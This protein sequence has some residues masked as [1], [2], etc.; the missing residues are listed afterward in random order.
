MAEA[1]LSITDD[2][3]E[4]TSHATLRRAYQRLRGA[5]RGHVEAAAPGI[6]DLIA[7][8]R[9]HPDPIGRF[10]RPRTPEGRAREPARRHLPDQRSRLELAR[11]QAF[12]ISRAVGAC[13]T[14]G[15]PG[16]EEST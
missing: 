14:I 15:R 1:L 7:S 12:G 16:P 11:T 2:R 5:A 13:A 10:L 8:T 3:A 4:R 6:A 9:Q